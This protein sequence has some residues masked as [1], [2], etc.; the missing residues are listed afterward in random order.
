MKVIIIG[1]GVASLTAG[2]YFALEGYQV[3]IYEF[4]RY[5]IDNN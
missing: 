5:R 1:S 3:I 4:V 2:A